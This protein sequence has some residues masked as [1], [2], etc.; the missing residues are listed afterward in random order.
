MTN[1]DRIDRR[2][3]LKKSG[4]VGAAAAA[5]ATALGTSWMDMPVAEAATATGVVRWGASVFTR[6]AQHTQQQAVKAL[7][8]KVGR[9]FDVTHFRMPWTSSLSNQFTNWSANTG[10]T[11]LLSWFA[12]G[13][14]GPLSWRGIANGDRDAWITTQARTLKATGWKNG[15]IS[16]HGEPEDEARAG[17]AADWKAAYNRVHT[18]F[19]NVGVTGWKWVAVLMGSTYTTGKAGAWLPP[20][21]DICGVDAANRYHCRQNP[22]KSFEFMLSGA[23]NYSKAHN[24]RLYVVEIGS[25]EGEP[26]RKATWFNEARATMKRWPEVMGFSYISEN[27]DCSYWADSTSSSLQ[28][29]AAMGRDAYFR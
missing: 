29:F 19:D 10:H 28:A 8:E 3:F 13:P 6:G 24:K 20:R 9:R 2:S 23:R 15:F 1:I 17:N 26:G 21:Y 7:E 5:G 12:R 4:L 25:V 16:F 22:W 27:T 18:I 14:G 11:Q